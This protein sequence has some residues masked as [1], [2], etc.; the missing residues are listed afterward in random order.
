[1]RFD[2]DEKPKFSF[3]PK[4]KHLFYLLDLVIMAALFYAGAWGFRT[5]VGEKKLA[6][7]AELRVQTQTDGA[8]MLAQADSVLR[9]ER[10]RLLD[11]AADSASWAEDLNDRR[12]YLENIAAE[13]Q[14]VAQ[15]IPPMADENLDLQ[16]KA[17]TSLNDV[18][19]NKEELSARRAE[20]A[21]LQA[22]AAQAARELEEA[23]RRNEDSASRLANARSLR[24]IEPVGIFPAKSGLAL[25]QD[26]S[27][28]QEL[29]NVEF[30]RSFWKR[31]IADVGLYA[32][33]GL[34]SKDVSSG[35]EVGLVVTR[36]LVHRRLG[37][38]LSAGYSIL[39]DPEGSNDSSPFAAAALRL[40]PFYRERFHLGLGARAAEEE[41][42]PF[43]SIGVGR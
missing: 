7:Q 34:G 36:P 18:R 42:T 5:W 20:L 22:R 40:S 14:R 2:D 17:T 11:A 43:L 19:D 23:H 3:R 12:V 33:L 39:T 13:Q 25:R 27:D 41:V 26:I 32:A 37:L 1:M 6:Q 30:R 10:A 4:W 15:A 9:V 28:S 24:T 29:T 35:K 21:D 8:R 31:G 38:D 16:Y